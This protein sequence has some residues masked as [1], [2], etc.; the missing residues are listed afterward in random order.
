MFS[1]NEFKNQLQLFHGMNPKPSRVGWGSFAQTLDK[2]LLNRLDILRPSR[3]KR[4]SFI[5]RHFD[6]FLKKH[7]S[8]GRRIRQR[9]IWS[10]DEIIF[11]TRDP[12]FQGRPKNVSVYNLTQE[13][14]T[15]IGNEALKSIVKVAQPFEGYFPDYDPSEP[16]HQIIEQEQWQKLQKY[17][18][19][20][21]GVPIPLLQPLGPQSAQY[22]AIYGQNYAENM[23]RHQEHFEEVQRVLFQSPEFQKVWEAH[24]YA[25]YD[26]FVI[27]NFSVR[28]GTLNAP[29]FQM[30]GGVS[31][32]DMPL[33]GK[34]FDVLQSRGHLNELFQGDSIDE[35]F[36][37]KS[38]Q[39]YEDNSC[40]LSAILELYARKLNHEEEKDD[41]E[42][43]DVEAK[44]EG[45]GFE[46]PKK[47]KKSFIPSLKT[48]DKVFSVRGEKPRLTY[49]TNLHFY[50]KV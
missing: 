23:R 27:Y 24:K 22:N 47:P 26:A 35:D 17:V 43:D 30:E 8:G 2:F 39:H 18:S 40:I 32:L 14:P 19:T 12:L 38:N 21:F 49:E 20:E 37:H 36:W 13:Q 48:P 6:S 3:L 31:L 16:H 4:S 46:T 45:N 5:T 34:K 33:E 9:K 1:S 15:R 11:Y 44:L 41:E 50:P 28:I 10:F 42:D 25:G 7:L 29:V